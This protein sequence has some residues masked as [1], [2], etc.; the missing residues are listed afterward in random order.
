MTTKTINC[1]NCGAN[2]EIKGKKNQTRCT[3]C[4]ASVFLDNK[5]REEKEERSALNDDV[6]AGL[7]M[8]GAGSYAQADL[9]FSNCCRLYRKNP[10]VYFWKG[11]AS[12]RLENM[13]QAFFY[14]DKFIYDINDIKT[15]LSQAKDIIGEG[16]FS[17]LFD[18]YGL[19][20]LFNW[21][22]IEDLLESIVT[23][24]PG[25]S[26]MDYAY[27][28]LAKHLYETCD[29]NHLDV[30]IQKCKKAYEYIE[31]SMNLTTLDGYKSGMA[32]NL[33]DLARI[34]YQLHQVNDAKKMLEHACEID[35]NIRPYDWYTLIEKALE[36][37]SYDD[38]NS[39]IYKSLD[40]SPEEIITSFTNETQAKKTWARIWLELIGYALNSCTHQAKLGNIS[41]NK[42]DELLDKF[43]FAYRKVPNANM[44]YIDA[45][46]LE[47]FYLRPIYLELAKYACR[48]LDF[49]LSESYLD[50]ANF[51]ESKP[52]HPEELI[53][54]HLI[55]NNKTLSEESG[56]GYFGLAEIVKQNDRRDLCKK[57]IKKVEFLLNIYKKENRS[58]DENFIVET[59]RQLKFIMH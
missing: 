32:E 25:T 16:A 39:Y 52:S 47:L 19:S 24:H 27:K 15:Y 49:I 55:S 1:P 20:L 14:L 54:P 29:I 10:I 21:E 41:F 50:K 31:R 22:S 58:K 7:E 12:Y 38:V 23:I 5:E 4:G 43:L 56:Y 48:N 44:I 40:E 6:E 26:S 13:Q 33:F 46:K 8:L 11:I 3:Y 53:G 17:T 36:A 9:Y 18:G 37:G 34:Y 45:G 59:N 35:P 2:L 30:S 57:N 28:H 51:G 42:W